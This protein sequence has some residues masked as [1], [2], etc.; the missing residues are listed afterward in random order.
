MNKIPF[1]LAILAIIIFSACSDRTEKKSTSEDEGKTC[2]EKI[3]EAD[4]EAGQIRNHACETQSLSAAIHT[5]VKTLKELDF[6][7]CPPVFDKA[8]NKHIADWEAIVEIS[9]KYPD[10]R[11]EMHDLFME[12]EQ[13]PDQEEFK[14]R[15]DKMWASWKEVEQQIQ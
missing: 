9:D 15:V 5:Y 14:K 3:M 8:F 10:L 1:A 12:L 6:G 13:S 7:D 2:I 4:A 11:G